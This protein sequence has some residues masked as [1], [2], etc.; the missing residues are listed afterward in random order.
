[1]DRNIKRIARQIVAGDRGRYIDL[2]VD[3]DGRLE[4]IPTDELREDAEQFRGQPE[5][6]ALH[7]MLEDH[8]A[9]G[10]WEFVRPEEIGALTDGAI[11]A[12]WV[13]RDDDG[14]LTGVGKVYWDSNY[15]VTSTVGE[16]LAGR[17]V[18]WQGGQTHA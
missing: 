18:V 13:D 5:M 3:A 7:D 8:T 14:K 1:M 9:N 11:L 2:S 10:D 12:D 6:S 17:A 15:Q 4:L 16:L